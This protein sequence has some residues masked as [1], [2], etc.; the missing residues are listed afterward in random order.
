MEFDFPPDVMMLRD[1][2]QRFVEREARPLEM[3]YLTGGELE[4]EEHARLRDAIEQM[5]LWGANVPECY[6]GVGLDLV[7]ACVMEE[8]LGKTFL[9]LEKGDV[10]VM[11]YACKGDQVERFLQPALSGGRR[12][13]VAARE[14]EA[15]GVESWRTWA[16]LDEDSYMINGEKLLPACSQPDDFYIVFTN[17]R[18]GATAFLLDADRHELTLEPISGA[19]VLKLQDCQVGS[20]SLLGEPGQ[21]FSLGSK[22]APYVWIR[23][24]AHSVGI[25]DRLLK[26]GVTFAKD[27]TWF[28]EQLIARPAVQ[29]MLADMQVEMESVRWLVYHAAWTVDRGAQAHIPAAKVRIATA[30]MLKHA[31][32]HV[33]MVYG[34]AS[35][36]W[37]GREVIKDR[38][39]PK[40]AHKSLE[41]ARALVV[42]ALVT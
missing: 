4:P 23:E 3:K 14:P 24:G 1:M 27:W 36:I 13:Y 38:W 42:N 35:A 33:T 30:E 12:A 22:E 11:L 5:G 29:R 32:D 40:V 39:F 17:T 25:T 26:M 18:R 7:T 37:D 2:L 28:E 41:G 19:Q 20:D 31:V 16:N 6:G 15:Q 8:E 9:P 10:P 21:A 34:G